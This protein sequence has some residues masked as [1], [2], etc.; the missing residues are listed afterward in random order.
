MGS[1][2]RRAKEISDKDISFLGNYKFQVL[3]QSGDKVYNIDIQVPS[4][5]CIDH[6]SGHICKHLM[7]AKLWL[8]RASIYDRIRA[9]I[10]NN[11]QWSNGQKRILSETKRDKVSIKCAGDRLY[12]VYV[13]KQTTSDLM[14]PSVADDLC[15]FLDV[16]GWKVA[17]TET[18][19]EQFKNKCYELRIGE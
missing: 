11:P 6:K 5:T 12:V 3:S 4:C 15:G 2:L 8:D 9:T 17:Y 18:E 14:T 7:A 1:R 13:N 16:D 19:Y 10:K